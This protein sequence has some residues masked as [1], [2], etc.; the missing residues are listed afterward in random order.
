[1]ASKCIL[2]FVLV[3][4]MGRLISAQWGNG[5]WGNFG[6]QPSFSQPAVQL[7]GQPGI[8]QGRG[9]WGNEPR[10]RFFTCIGKNTNDDEMRVT[11]TESQNQETWN[12]NRW[13]NPQRIHM[14]AVVH[15]SSRSQ[16]AGRFQL[17]VT[18]YGRVEDGCSSE[19]LG[20]IVDNFQ[21]FN[22]FGRPRDSNSQTG[23]LG[24]A[25]TLRPSLGHTASGLV[26]GFE[27]LEELN[28]RGLAL[29]LS[30][31]IRNGMC[32]DIIP[33]CCKI[34][35]DS[36]SATTP[37]YSHFNSFSQNQMGMGGMG[38][39][40]G[41]GGMGQVGGVS[42]VP[43]MPI[44]Q[45]MTGLNQGSALPSQQPGGLPGTQPAGAGLMFGN[46]QGRK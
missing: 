20:R 7:G 14:D 11:F 43:G 18:R 19:A 22:F 42:G 13:F 15:V 16:T 45:P 26:R 12:I 31:N 33:L 25:F 17:V 35:R 9:F 39:M 41:I 46:T 5:G 38:G 40:G 30:M 37:I 24:S 10:Q 44:G 1:M 28:G 29:C 23:V 36:V 27:A 4:V 8:G 21:G 6:Q 3:G 34:G 2:I 32:Q